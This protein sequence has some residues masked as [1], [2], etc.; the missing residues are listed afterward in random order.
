MNWI[1]FIIGAAILIIIRNQ[2]FK[3]IDEDEKKALA[4]PGTATFLRSNFQEVIDYLLSKPNYTI[5]FERSDAIKIGV[6]LDSDYYLIQQSYPKVFIAHIKYS[7]LEQEWRFNR[8][9]SSQH[10]IY[11]LKKNT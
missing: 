5:L 1:L 9:E 3:K 11:E 8:N 7:N 4:T 6:S 2:V 10:I